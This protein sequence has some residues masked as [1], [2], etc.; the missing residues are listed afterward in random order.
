MSLA[1]T[2]RTPAGIAPAPLY[3]AAVACGRMRLMRACSIAASTAAAAA[4]GLTATAT[5]VFALRPNT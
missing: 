2:E 5:G 1:K 4:A 3:C